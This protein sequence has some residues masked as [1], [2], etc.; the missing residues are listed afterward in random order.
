MGDPVNAV[1][2]MVAGWGWGFVQEKSRDWKHHLQLF[3][4][5]NEL[6]TAGQEGLQEPEKGVGGQ[7]LVLR[8]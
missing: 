3:K 1:E 7:R 4:S 6:L 2:R 8:P 5:H